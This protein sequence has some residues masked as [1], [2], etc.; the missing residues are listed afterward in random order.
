MV[1]TLMLTIFHGGLFPTR[2]NNLI[3]DLMNIS[4]KGRVYLYVRNPFGNP[5]ALPDASPL[6]VWTDA[7]A[8]AVP[9]ERAESEM[10][11]TSIGATCPSRAP[12]IDRGLVGRSPE[13]LCPTYGSCAA[14]SL[15]WL[16]R[17]ELDTFQSVKRRG[18]R[19]NRKEVVD[20]VRVGVG[21]DGAFRSSRRGWPYS[22][23]DLPGNKETKIYLEFL[24]PEYFP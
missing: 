10:S 2:K 22:T 3:T 15:R 6:N 12:R 16:S 21:A 7:A 8:R 5:R 18:P 4:D 23:A 11:Q 20:T 17:R 13:S 24:N 14:M 19:V 9:A 1:E